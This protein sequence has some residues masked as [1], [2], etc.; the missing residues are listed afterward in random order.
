MNTEDIFR[1]TYLP[2]VSFFIKR[3]KT[4]GW[5]QEKSFLTEEVTKNRS[6][7]MKNN[8]KRTI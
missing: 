8:F 3:M 2:L 1:N 7:I 5:R 6:L 4:L